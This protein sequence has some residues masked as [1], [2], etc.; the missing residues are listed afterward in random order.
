MSVETADFLVIGLG[1][2]G[3]AAFRA[4]A[5]RGLRVIGLEQFSIGH[6]RGSS[7]GETRIIRKAYFEHP[8]YVPL[9]RRSYE[10]WNELE[11][12]TG[13]KLYHETGLLIAGPADGEAIPGAKLAARLHGLSI[14]DLR[15]VDVERRF[16]W[17]QLPEGLE[18][19]F[20]PEAGFLEVEKCVKAQVRDG[21][22]LGGRAI[23]GERVLDWSVEG[24]AVRVT[25]DRAR[26]E[27]S[28]LVIAAGAWATRMLAD[29]KV[30]LEVVRKPTVWF[31]SGRI[32]EAPSC[33]FFVEREGRAFYGVPSLE[34][35][36]TKLAEHT[37]GEPVDPDHVDRTLR[38]ED[39]RPL[40]EFRRLALRGLEPD[41]VRYSVC[42]YTLTPDR[43]FVIDRQ[44]VA[45]NVAFACGFSGHGFKFAPVV[46]EALA[47]LVTV[48]RT[49]LPVDFLRNRWK[50]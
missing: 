3:G 20:E 30:P 43:H 23:C 50:A 22:R 1:A 32:E 29:Q 11:A 35:G 2:M 7:H 12:A 49:A 9:L 25:T 21:Q 45:A 10:L 6:A 14:E 41:P 37:G 46:G 5:T 47:D 18:C 31:R 36:V 4:L 33:G 39:V 13:Q 34:A 15:R 17:M 24:S 28:G 48:G 19:V 42:M 38:E 44:G 8:D 40:D 27:A 16:P 26:Y